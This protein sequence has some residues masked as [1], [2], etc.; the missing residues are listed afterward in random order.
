ML[1][2][3]G[4]G[5]DIKTAEEAFGYAGD[6]FLD[7]SSNMNPWGPPK[8]V[9]T[10]FEEGWKQVNRYP[11]PAVRKLRQKLSETYQIPMESILVG[12]GA[13]ELI[14]LSVRVLNSEVTAITRPS[15]SE[16][17]EAIEKQKGQIYEIP[18]KI[19]HDFILQMSDV[20]KAPTNVDTLFLGHPNNPNGKLIP[21]SILQFLRNAKKNI[22]IDEA[23][24]DF[25]PHGETHS[26][27][28]QA[29]ETEG[30]F[31]I[32]SMTKF[33]AIP[34]IRLGFIV[35]HPD[36]IRQMQRLQVQWSV[37]HLAQE[38]GTAVLDEADY[39][40]KTKRWLQEERVWM[41]KQLEALGLKVFPSDVNFL[42]FSIPS[43]CSIRISSLQDSLGKRGVL[44]RDASRFKGLD[45]SYGRLA[46]RLRKENERLI[47]EMRQILA[48]GGKMI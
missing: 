5:G 15:F 39:I 34:G 38:I 7:Y 18:L 10:I 11:D 47:G 46:I 23:F 6:Q 40:D 21:S 25:V 44:I 8:V 26:L 22:I 45:S 42:L 4:H 28:Q 32:R 20:V 19:E 29:A 17:E 41:T 30:L 13:A 2:Q 3:F 9:K 36:W 33:F 31:V 12:N 43:T 16:Y 24:I 27:L 35:A 48:G 37:N 1:E 14:D